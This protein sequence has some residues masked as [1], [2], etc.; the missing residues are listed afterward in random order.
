MKITVS[1][2]LHKLIISALPEEAPFVATGAPAKEL[3]VAEI[4]NPVLLTDIAK[5]SGLSSVRR[6]AVMKLYEFPDREISYDNVSVR[7]SPIVYPRVWAPSIDT[8]L[9]A[10]AI[11]DFLVKTGRLNQA[12]SCLE[13]GTGSGFLGKYILEKKKK[14]GKELELLHLTDINKDA[15][16]CAMDNIEAARGKTLMYYTHTRPDAKLSVDRQYDLVIANPPYIP[17]PSAKKNNPYEGLMVYEEII[18]NAG[19][20]LRPD[21]MFMTMISSTSRNFIKPELDKVFKLK[22]V[23][24]LRVPLKI[25]IVTAG[26]SG[27]SKSWMSYLKKNK[28]IEEDKKEISGYRYWQIIEVVAGKLK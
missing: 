8:V 3:A 12:G 19:K 20:M 11:R 9:F 26:F 7:W 14:S 6:D 16:K 28:F 5:I 18:R 17:R 21:S 13:I 24:R 4:L 27:Q 2:D 1:P 22:T 15:I 23:A 10:K 25:P